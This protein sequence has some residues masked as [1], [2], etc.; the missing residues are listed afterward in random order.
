M[1]E[2]VP[3]TNPSYSPIELQPYSRPGG[4]ARPIS[5]EPVTLER[6]PPWLT[7]KWQQGENYRDLKGLTGGVGL[8][9]VC[10]EALCPNISGCWEHRTE[11]FLIL[12]DT[13]T[14][15]CGFCANKTGRP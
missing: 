1:S 10:E 5:A 2:Q 4:P 8:D 11:T 6:K 15:P 3:T 14:R 13:C 7:V 12:G 9:P